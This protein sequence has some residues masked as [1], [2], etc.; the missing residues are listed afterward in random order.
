MLFYI[1]ALLFLMLYCFRCPDLFTAFFGYGLTAAR[2]SFHGSHDI[3]DSRYSVFKVR[4]LIM[5]TVLSVIK[6]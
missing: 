5:L 3:F 1:P 2:M 6:N 4:L